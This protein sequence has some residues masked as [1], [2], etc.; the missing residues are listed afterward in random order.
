MM[1]LIRNSITMVTM[2]PNKMIVSWSFFMRRSRRRCT[3]NEPIKLNR[4]VNMKLST[5]H[6]QSIF[7]I[8]RKTSCRTLTV[9]TCFN[10]FLLN[11]D[12]HS[13]LKTHKN[14]SILLFSFRK[15]NS[16]IFFLDVLHT[17]SMKDAEHDIPKM[18]ILFGN[19][20]VSQWATFQYSKIHSSNAFQI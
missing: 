9:Q 6:V 7:T 13:I 5:K 15:L 10:L 17:K 14:V 20:S 16:L 4:N 8:N 11:L 2:I 1:K 3:Y 12:S 19:L 18:L